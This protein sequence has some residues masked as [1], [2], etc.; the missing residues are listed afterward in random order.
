MAFYD[1]VKDIA[2]RLSIEYSHPLWMVSRWLSRWGLSKTKLLL[3]FNNEKP[4][5]YFRRKIHGLSRQQFE[6]ESRDYVAA[7]CGYLHCF[8]H[9]TKP[10]QPDT[11]DLFIDGHC[12]VQS[13]SSGWVVAL[14]DIHKGD[15]ALDVCAA[16]G[17][18]SVLI[19]EIAAETG[20]VYSCEI[21]ASRMKLVVD[22]V[23][24]MR[25]TNVAM[26]QC[27]GKSPPFSRTFKHILL[28]APCLGTGVL[29]RHPEGR[30][31]KKPDDLARLTLLQEKLLEASAVMV[32]P[33][34]VLV[35]STCSLEP[36][37]NELRIQAFLAAHPD[38]ILEAPPESVPQNFIDGSGFLRITPFDHKLDGMFGARLKKT[39]EKRAS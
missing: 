10:L 27:D 4:E 7:P 28:D 11:V 33:G 13:P 22:T 5:I 9:L 35:Y 25:L 3:A 8:Y 15:M 31:I 26:L 30:W 12:T 24:R 37:E 38:F 21:N 34:G 19:G 17:G 29:H 14:L 1:Q 20:R 6:T 39:T 23:R 16:P 18:K 2:E 32:A 36:E